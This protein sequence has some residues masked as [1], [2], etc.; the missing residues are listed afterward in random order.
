MIEHLQPTRSEWFSPLRFR[1]GEFYVAAVKRLENKQA[2]EAVGLADSQ[3]VVFTGVAAVIA[4]RWRSSF[5]GPGRESPRLMKRLRG[6]SIADR[7]DVGSNT[8]CEGN[9]PAHSAAR[10]QPGAV[11]R[12]AAPLH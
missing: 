2:R 8:L 10:G 5:V 7:P 4:F 3:T 11:Q 12:P 9:H 1:E 6:K